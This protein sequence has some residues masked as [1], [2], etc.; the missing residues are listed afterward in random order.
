V[1]AT[2]LLLV[3]GLAGCGHRGGDGVATAQSG[4]ATPSASGRAGAKGLSPQELAAKFGQ[5][6]RDNGVPNFPD[7]KVNANGGTSIDVPKGVDP[8]QVQAAQEKCKAYLPDG[9][10]PTKLDP[11]R[12]EQLRRLAQCMRDHG[13]KKF[14]D[15]TDQ[16]IQVNGQDSSLNPDDPAFKAAMQECGKYG[17]SP[18][19]GDRPG[20]DSGGG[21]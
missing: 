6:M 19:P 1:L 14:P 18:A 13:V 8:Q 11:Q 15:P 4:R 21:A 7:P 10:E 20:L 16:G 17:P 3:A 2:G 9:G 12:L 5:C